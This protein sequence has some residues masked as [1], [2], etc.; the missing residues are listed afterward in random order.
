MALGACPSHL[1]RLVLSHG[2]ALTASG[3]LLG[4]AVALGLTRLLGYLLYRVSPRDPWAFATALLVM[5][6]A[7]LTACS[8]PAWRAARTDP[9]GALRS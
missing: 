2:L 6:V 1:L 5:T 4:A 9:V 8:V 7:A 3:V